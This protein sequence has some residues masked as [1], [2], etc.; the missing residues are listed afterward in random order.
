MW[1]IDYLPAFIHLKW[2]DYTAKNRL[3]VY[4]AFVIKMAVKLTDLFSDVV[5]GILL[6]FI[7]YK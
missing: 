1:R 3:W 7:L 5:L 2:H 6:T 4:V